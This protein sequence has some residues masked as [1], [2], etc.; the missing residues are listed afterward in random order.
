[1]LIKEIHTIED[2]IVIVGNEVLGMFP[3]GIDPRLIKEEFNGWIAL[4]NI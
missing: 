4:S 3:Y 2:V 1:M